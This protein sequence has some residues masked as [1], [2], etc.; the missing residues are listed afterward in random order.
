M[1]LRQAVAW[2]VVMALAGPSIAVAA[3][4]LTC[5]LDSHHH[6]TPSSSEASCH[7]HQ[8]SPDG[9]GMSASSQT[10]CHD[11]GDLPS[12]ILDLALNAAAVPSVL[13]ATFAVDTGLAAPTDVRARQHHRRVDSGPANRPLRV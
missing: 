2:L 13:P 11:A 5:A 7:G 9:V 3:C 8:A 1:M 10:T 6:G 12:A 4:E